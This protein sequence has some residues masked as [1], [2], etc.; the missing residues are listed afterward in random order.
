MYHSITTQVN[1]FQQI[2]KTLGISP[3]DLLASEF[4]FFA[5][6]SFSL[7]LDNTEVMVHYDRI[8]QQQD[9]VDSLLF[10]Y[11]HVLDAS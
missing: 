3:E 10:S 4:L 1:F 8:V 9:Q 7:F 6:L 2:E 11:L 5:K